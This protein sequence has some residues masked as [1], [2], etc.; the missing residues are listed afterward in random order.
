MYARTIRIA[1]NRK[2]RSITAEHRAIDARSTGEASNG[3]A[4]ETMG[5]SDKLY[6]AAAS[7][8][9]W[10]SGGAA[11]S[12]YPSGAQQDD[13]RG[14]TSSSSS[15]WS[16]ASNTLQSALNSSSE[17]ASSLYESI[18]SFS[19]PASEGKT[20][21]ETPIQNTGTFLT[22]PKTKKPNIGWTIHNPYS[23][24]RG[25][26]NQPSSS[27]EAVRSLLKVVPVK[28]EQDSLP[29]QDEEEP[30]ERQDTASSLDST[31]PSRVWNIHRKG[32]LQFPEMKLP[33]N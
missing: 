33:R 20:A 23:N 4:I 6:E 8:T 32:L 28:P 24:I 7:V 15:Y 5:Y 19:Y 1:P 22:A 25:Y 14:A 2:P 11:A 30:L 21:T 26:Q 3:G 12:R 13:T 29:Y 18:Y 27:L 17:A 10:A 31:F 9:G 16:Y